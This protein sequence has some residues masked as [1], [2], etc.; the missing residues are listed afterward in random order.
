ME[1][2]RKNKYWLYIRPNCRRELKVRDY[3][4]SQGLECFVPMQKVVRVIHG[5][6]VKLDVP[7]MGNM[8]F[9]NTSYENLLESKRS[10][11]ALGYPVMLRMDSANPSQPIIVPDKQMEDFIRVCNDQYS[12]FVDGRYS[13]NLQEN[14]YV[15]VISGRFAGV[16]GYYARPFKDKCVVCIVEGLAVCTTYIPAYALKIIKKGNGNEKTNL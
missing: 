9:V 6:E 4:E 7:V 11:E 14:D 2:S 16:R 1:Y 8:V 5:E 13:K 12:R 15:E 10:L 3:L